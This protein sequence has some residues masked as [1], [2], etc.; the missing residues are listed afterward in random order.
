VTSANALWRVPLS[1][2]RGSTDDGLARNE[3]NSVVLRACARSACNH[4]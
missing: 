2:I 4:V 3:P 1:A